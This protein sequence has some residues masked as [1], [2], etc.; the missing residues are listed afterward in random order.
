[1]RRVASDSSGQVSKMLGERRAKNSGERA[2]A[3][4]FHVDGSGVCCQFEL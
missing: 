1:M 4:G 2:D 3:S